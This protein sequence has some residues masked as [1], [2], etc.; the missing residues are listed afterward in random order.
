M[1]IRWT[2]AAAD[3]LEGIAEYLRVNHPRHRE[4]TLQQIYRK[5]RELRHWPMLGRAGLA[6]H[7]R[8]IVFPPLPYVAVY[9]ITGQVIEIL[10]IDHGAQDR[11]SIN[12]NV[13]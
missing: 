12:L 9:R 6:P 13:N 5:I 3:D 10:R 8:E 1:R 2:P 4:K 11:Q 7:T